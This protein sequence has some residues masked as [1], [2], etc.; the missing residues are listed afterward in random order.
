MNTTRWITPRS[1]PD[2]STIFARPTGLAAGTLLAITTSS[3]AITWSAAAIDGT[4][5]TATSYTAQYR[6]TS[7]GGSWTQV[8]GITGTT[9][10]ITGLSSTFSI[11]GGET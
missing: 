7:V 11:S 3:V 1:T 8:T 2:S 5:D 6:V 4:H 10:T 9:T